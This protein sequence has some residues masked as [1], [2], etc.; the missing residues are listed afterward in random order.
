VE[1]VDIDELV[2][3]YRTNNYF[4][5]FINQSSTLDYLT[6]FYNLPVATS[7]E[8]FLGSFNEKYITRNCPKY[9]SMAECFRR[10]AE[11]K[12]DELARLFYEEGAKNVNDLLAH[13]A[14]TGNLETF[15]LA[16]E[17]GATNDA[18]GLI[19]AAKHGHKN[20][21]QWI[22]DIYYK[23]NQRLMSNLFPLR[24]KIVY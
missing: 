8:E 2:H 4:M 6:K 11:Y 22:E 17:L 10:T 21:I 1:D 19:L 9:M 5:N 12:N 15:K 24:R 13:S 23:Y 18:E 3:L 16:H 14:E 20:I 7:F